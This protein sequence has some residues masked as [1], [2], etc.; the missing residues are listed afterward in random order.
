MFVYC[1]PRSQ[2][3]P[4]G[5]LLGWRVQP[6]NIVHLSLLHKLLLY[7]HQEY[8]LEEQRARDEEAREA[9]ARV[10]AAAA[11]TAFQAAPPKAP[12][13]SAEDIAELTDSYGFSGANLL[14]C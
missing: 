13:I 8:E 3:G 2:T 7:L 6:L 4:F 11:G 1:A 14:P 12:E 9:A 10:T 5:F